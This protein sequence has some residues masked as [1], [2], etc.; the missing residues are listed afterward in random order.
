[1]MTLFLMPLIEFM[2]IV[3]PKSFSNQCMEFIL[4]CRI[5]M[6]KAPV[7]ITSHSLYIGCIFFDWVLDC[8]KLSLMDRSQPI[9]FYDGTCHFCHGL[10]QFILRHEASPTIMF[11][12]LQ[13]LVSKRELPGSIGEDLTTVV[14]VKKERFLIKSTAVVHV[15]WVLGGKWQLLAI[16]LWLIPWPIRNFGYWVVAKY[17]YRI[18]GR[19]NEC[20]ALSDASR[21][22]SDS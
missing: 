21:L 11:C 16:L 19:S 9:L 8:G 22:I 6:E 5:E 17:R 2:W 3:H 18:F 12:H 4:N 1:M 13:S 20:V 10:V 7:F 15:L 14:F